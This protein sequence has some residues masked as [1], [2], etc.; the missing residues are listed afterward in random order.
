MKYIVPIICSLLLIGC[1]DSKPTEAPASEAVTQNVSEPTAES[2][3][4]AVQPAEETVA[5]VPVAVAQPQ[6]APEPKIEKAV[7]APSVEKAAPVAKSTPAPK[8]EQIVP[9]AAP[10]AA[11]VNGAAVFAQKCASCHGQKSEKS[12]LGKSQI[13]AGWDSAKTKEALH[14]Y[15]AGTYGKE[16]KAMMQAQAKG[17]SDAQIDALAKHISAL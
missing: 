8:A 5:E 4:E 9:A 6:T 15:Q 1:S 10:V 17:L 12:A 11:E 2:T 14:G 16:M 7:A 13:I 3:S